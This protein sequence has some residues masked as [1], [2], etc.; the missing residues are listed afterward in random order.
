M[1]SIRSGLHGMMPSNELRSGSM[2]LKLI[3]CHPVLFTQF[4]RRNSSKRGKLTSRFSS[5]PTLDSPRLS[6][7]TQCLQLSRTGMQPTAVLRA[8]NAP[9]QA[10]RTARAPRKARA[11]IRRHRRAPTPRRHRASAR[12]DG[13]DADRDDGLGACFGPRPQSRSCTRTVRLTAFVTPSWYL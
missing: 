1:S 12:A 8:R 7:K 10:P 3:N 2:Q 13:R 5:I 11:D 9:Y 6:Y 4:Q